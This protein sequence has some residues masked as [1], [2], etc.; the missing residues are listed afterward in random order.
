MRVQCKESLHV[1]V[2]VFSP[3]LPSMHSTLQLKYNVLHFLF[4]WKKYFI[5]ILTSEKKR[6]WWAHMLIPWALQ[7]HNSF[8]FTES[9]S[10]FRQIIH[11]H[12][13]DTILPSSGYNMKWKWKS[14][15]G[16]K[17]VHCYVRSH[18]HAGNR[19]PTPWAARRA[20]QGVGF[21]LPALFFLT[22]PPTPQ[23]RN[24]ILLMDTQPNTYGTNSRLAVA[25]VGKLTR[26]FLF[27][28]GKE[29]ILVRRL[30]QLPQAIYCSVIIRVTSG[31]EKGLLLHRL[32][33]QRRLSGHSQ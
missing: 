6:L 14:G 19:N 1:L 7:I 5:K 17:R 16:K 12:H 20:A 32:S 21:Q 13:Q 30:G 22:H 8:H 24:K 11:C 10:T 29:Y 25:S 9:F 28:F 26:P 4:P 15:S 33:K 23:V 2:V 27:R 18:M 31:F 3:P